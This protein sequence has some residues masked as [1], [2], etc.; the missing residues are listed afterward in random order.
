MKIKETKMK[1]RNEIIQHY[2]IFLSIFFHIYHALS[3]ENICHIFSTKIR[4]NMRTF[5]EFFLEKLGQV[6]VR[7]LK[8][9]CLIEFIK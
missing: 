2:F 3:H 4:L 6:R 9:Y 8:F 7:F 5:I 1:T